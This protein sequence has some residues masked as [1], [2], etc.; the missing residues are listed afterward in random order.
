ME[1]VLTFES[2][3]AVS[4][5][6]NE[7][8]KVTFEYPSGAEIED[9]EKRKEDL[10]NIPQFCFPDDVF[11]P[12]MSHQTMSEEFVFVLTDITGSRRY[13]VCRRQVQGTAALAL[14]VVS[15]W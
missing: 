6:A 14:A 2:F 4:A 12:E 10:A 11:G 8:P 5:G 9:V 13:G 3:F 1:D 15:R 7:P